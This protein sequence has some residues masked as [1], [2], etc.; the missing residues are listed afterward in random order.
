M[1]QKQIKEKI[2]DIFSYMLGV[3]K[4]SITSETTM[5]D[6][7]AD[8]LEQAEILLEIEKE[9]RFDFHN[10]VEMCTKNFENICLY[11]EKALQQKENN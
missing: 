8:Y 5:S 7:G 2:T 6:L 11:V 9:F 4:T 10:Y 3:E 1:D